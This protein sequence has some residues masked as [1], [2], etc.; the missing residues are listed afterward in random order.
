MFYADAVGLYSVLRSMR[1]FATQPG[2]DA[3][4]WQPARLLSELAESGKSL[5]ESSR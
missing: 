4:F 2:G 3:V 1:R 5:A